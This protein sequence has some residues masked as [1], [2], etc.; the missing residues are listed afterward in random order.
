[1]RNFRIEYASSA[2]VGGL[3]FADFLAF[4]LNRI[5]T[6][7]EKETLNDFD[8]KFMETIGLI[9]WNINLDLIKMKDE[10][11]K[12][13]FK[14]IDQDQKKIE[15]N[16]ASEREILKRLENSIEFLENIIRVYK[17]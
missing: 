4:T 2:N 12:D 8:K 14:Y 3:Q 6:N 1:L 11:K 15:L 5:I 16:E 7:V 9:N 13:P 17:N 10:F